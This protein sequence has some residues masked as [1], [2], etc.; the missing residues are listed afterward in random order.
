MPTPD[1]NHEGQELTN[2]EVNEF[3]NKIE[4]KNPI[5]SDEFIKQKL[6]QMTPDERE[7]LGRSVTREVT[8]QAMALFGNRNIM[9]NKERA[10]RNFPEL[11]DEEFETLCKRFTAS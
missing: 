5:T 8:A 9:V 6:D 3:L 11:S 7:A 2:K 4:K 1:D 10:R